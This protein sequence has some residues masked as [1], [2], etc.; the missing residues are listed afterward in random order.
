[1]A[2]NRHKAAIEV[3]V[4]MMSSRVMELEARRVSEG[5]YE[6]PASLT[7]RV[8]KGRTAGRSGDRQM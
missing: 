2:I 6:R 1:M 3:K 5:S 8:A 4:R 7:R